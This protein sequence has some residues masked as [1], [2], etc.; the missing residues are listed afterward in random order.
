MAAAYDLC[1]SGRLRLQQ[2]MAL[3][4]VFGIPAIITIWLLIDKRISFT[5][6]KKVIKSNLLLGLPFSS[7]A[8]LF[9]FICSSFAIAAG[10]AII[11]GDKKTMEGLPYLLSGVAAFVV[12]V[13]SLEYPRVAFKDSYILEDIIERIKDQPKENFPAYQDGIFIYNENGFTVGLDNATL[14]VLWTDIKKISAYKVDQLTVDCIV[15]DVELENTR[16]TINDETAGHMKFMETAAERLAGFKKDWFGIVAFP[17]F[18][19][20][21]TIVYQRK[22]HTT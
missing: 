17:A 20:N 10:L 5:E 8:C 18:E 11:F 22:S 12:A 2:N 4:I 19:T 9:I 1:T 7:Y 14:H 6:R 21:F 13:V 15:I 16:F 3:L